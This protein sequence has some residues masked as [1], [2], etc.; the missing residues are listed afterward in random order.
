MIDDEIRWQLVFANMNLKL[1]RKWD[2]VTPSARRDRIN[3][4]HAKIDDLLA[5]AGL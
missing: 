3:D 4:L 2:H 1:A 5:Q